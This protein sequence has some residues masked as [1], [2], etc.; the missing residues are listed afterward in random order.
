MNRE[1][2]AIS[3]HQMRGDSV[4][5]QTWG[6]SSERNPLSDSCRF[7]PLFVG[8]SGALSP[9]LSHPPLEPSLLAGLSGTHWTQWWTQRNPYTGPKHNG[10]WFTHTL[11]LYIHTYPTC[12]IDVSNVEAV[13]L[14]L[15]MRWSKPKV[16]N[17]VSGVLRSFPRWESPDFFFLF[18]C[19][20]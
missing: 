3:E 10:L 19:E 7:M 14:K 4:P 20:I 8:R 1:T 12:E 18:P 6:R 11:P 17:L 2:F 5:S 9:A 13:G 16:T 15:P